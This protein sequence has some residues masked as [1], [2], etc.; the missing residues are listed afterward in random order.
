MFLDT[1]I[2]IPYLY[3]NLAME[4]EAQENLNKNIDYYFEYANQ[5]LKAKI[6]NEVV[7]LKKEFPIWEKRGFSIVEDESV[8]E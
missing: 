7:E 3:N 8:N 5:K 6:I 2:I 1:N 4:Q